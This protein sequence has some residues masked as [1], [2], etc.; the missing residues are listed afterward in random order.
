[1]KKIT[2]LLVTLVTINTSIVFTCPVI[3]SNDSDSPI[4]VVD[5]NNGQSIYVKAG[6]Q[7]MINPSIRGWFD[8]TLAKLW[9]KH[10]TLDIHVMVAP[11]TFARKY[12][13]TEQ[14][15]ASE[16]PTLVLS[17][18]EIFAQAPTTDRYRVATF[19]VVNASKHEH[20][21]HEH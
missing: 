20:G 9:M 5:P 4:I 11:N 17:E 10:E 7:Q 15:C 16:T 13:I 18:I 21:D 1:M 19:E 6:E 2:A 8:R 14:Y 3:I 12:Q